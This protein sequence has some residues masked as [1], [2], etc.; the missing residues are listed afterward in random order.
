MSSQRL[1]ASPKRAP[2]ER[3]AGEASAPVT[4]WPQKHTSPFRPSGVGPVHSK[5]EE[6]GFI[7]EGRISK[8]LWT[9]FKTHMPTLQCEWELSRDRKREEHAEHRRA[10]CMEAVD[11]S[12]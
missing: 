7:L 3:K 2:Q 5:R 4:T 12:G 10:V 9:Y 8:G 6:L 1:P 11:R